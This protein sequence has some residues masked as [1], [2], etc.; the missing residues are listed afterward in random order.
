[1]KWFLVLKKLKTYLGETV[2][3]ETEGDIEFS[4]QTFL[5]DGDNYKFLY[6]KDT[7][8]RFIVSEVK[9]FRI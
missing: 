3:K 8:Y 5:K 9:I 6:K 4:A 2:G 1:M 7:V